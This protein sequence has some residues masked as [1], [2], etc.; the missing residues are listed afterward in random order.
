M[1]GFT[2]IEFLIILAIIGI[3]LAIAIPGIQNYAEDSYNTNVKT[4]TTQKNYE[5]IGGYKFIINQNGDP[6]QIIGSNGHGVECF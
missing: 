6:V 4:Q 5:C 2:L 1:K 3:F